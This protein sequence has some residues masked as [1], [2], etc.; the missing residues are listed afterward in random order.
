MNSWITLWNHAAE[1][2][3]AAYVARLLARRLS[4]ANRVGRLQGL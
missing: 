2:W 4:S 1:M 3:A